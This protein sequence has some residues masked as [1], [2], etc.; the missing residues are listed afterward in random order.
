MNKNFKCA[1]FTV[2]LASSLAAIN[3]TSPFCLAQ[4]LLDDFEDG[5][6]DGWQH[7]GPAQS[8]VVDG[9]LVISSNAPVPNIFDEFA[10]FI[11]MNYVPSVDSPS[12]TNG[13]A[14]VTV[15]PLQRDTTAGIVLRAKSDGSADYEFWRE[16][17]AGKFFMSRFDLNAEPQILELATT[18]RFAAPY[19]EGEEWIMEAGVVGSEISLKYWRPGDPEPAAPQLVAHNTAIPPFDPDFTTLY[20]AAW[21]LSPT[22]RIMSAAFDDLMFT[23]V[24]EP[25]AGSLALV[26]SLVVLAARRLLPTMYS[27]FLLRSLARKSLPG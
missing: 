16:P 18:E 21:H 5:M 19:E 20:V 1:H 14:R 9:R 13:F 3:L 12:Y 17:R 27:S 26:G 10:G 8:A 11:S 4:V 2:I 25:S 24:P 22:P 23:P 6:L 7:F 15:S